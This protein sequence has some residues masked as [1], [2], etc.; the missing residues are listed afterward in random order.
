M[1]L[2]TKNIFMCC[3][4]I[5]F[6]FT[7]IEASEVSVPN[8]PTVSLRKITEKCKRGINYSHIDFLNLQTLEDSTKSEDYSR[9]DSLIERGFKVNMC[10]NYSPIAVL[11]YQGNLNGVRYLLAKGADPTFVGSHASQD[12]LVHLAVMSGNK[13]LVAYLLEELKFSVDQRNGYGATPL[14]SAVTSGHG[15]IVDYL[16]LKGARLDL[17]D[18]E[19]KNVLMCAIEEALQNPEERTEILIRLLRQSTPELLKQ[20]YFSL[21][22]IYELP[23]Y[24]RL[25][26]SYKHLM[27]PD[28]ALAETIVTMCDNVEKN[29]RQIIQ[30]I[31]RYTDDQ[32]S[33]DKKLL[34]SLVNYVLERDFRRFY[35]MM[36]RNMTLTGYFNRTAIKLE[37]KELQEAFSLLGVYEFKRFV[38]ACEKEEYFKSWKRHGKGE[39]LISE[40]NK[41]IN[42]YLREHP[43]EEPRYSLIE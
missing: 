29:K 15:D 3:L 35:K 23:F 24:E 14:M 42:E 32:P 34:E 33:K 30:V 8:H 1:I 21:G 25:R 39:F 18:S 37:S 31:K 26:D 20:N 36:T 40:L 27:F 13:E 2:N 22:K 9:A 17:I 43:M 16:L 7:F 12:S 19:K 38:D 5:T 11:A 28:G 6:A 4:L 41:M 10:A